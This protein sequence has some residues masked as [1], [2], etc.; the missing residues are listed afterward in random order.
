MKYIVKTVFKIVLIYILLGEPLYSCK[1]IEKN[2]KDTIPNI[3]F[4]ISDQWS[5]VASDGSG[6]NKYPRTR[7]IDNLA[8]NGVRFT[9]AYS[10]FPVSSPAR[11]SMFTGQMPH[12]FGVKGNFHKVDRIS[13]N[14][15]TLGELFEKAG[16]EMG[17]FGKD[18]T[19]GGTTRGFGTRDMITDSGGWL[20]DGSIFD[21]IS[22]REAVEF[23]RIN[24][25]KPFFVTLSLINPH[26]ICTTTINSKFSY[27]GSFVEHKFLEP[28]FDEILL[29]GNHTDTVLQAMLPGYAKERAAVDYSTT[30]E[31]WLEYVRFYYVLIE[32]TD[33]NIGLVLKTLE[34]TGVENNTLVVFITDHGDMMS[35]HRMRQKGTFFEEA[36]RIP[37][38]L[39]WPGEIEFPKICDELVSTIDIMPTICDYAGLEI[40]QPI[41]GINLR[42]V[43]ENTGVNLREY[44]VCETSLARMVRFG[45][46]K[47]VQS[48]EGEEVLF[49]LEYDPG[50]GSNIA[51][52]T[53]MRPVLDSARVWLKEWTDKTNDWFTPAE[54]K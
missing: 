4:I 6:L 16:Y 23:I 18:H 25:D 21:P 30:E 19:G 2:I 13:K 3:V 22:T 29:P 54:Y 11:V 9:Q 50:E 12:Q 38:I 48:V 36:A 1:S 26:D 7:N 17:Y 35:A 27:G 14:F 51:A 53:D 40:S 32:N 39:S 45:K 42:P 28:R 43:I 37:F 41:D 52:H 46:Y 47:Y 15:E 24:K 20:S 44:L 10:S 31:E 33:W 8:S 5:A 34:E 49:D